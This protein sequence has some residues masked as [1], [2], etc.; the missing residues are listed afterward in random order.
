MWRLSI[1][2]VDEDGPF[3][4]FEGMARILTVIEGK[5]MVL[6]SEDG[7][8]D[9]AYCKP[10]VFSGEAKINSYL[11]NGPIRDFN[12]IYDPVQICAE[13]KLV[14]KAFNTRP[15]Q[16]LDCIYALYCIAG[17]LTVD[18]AEIDKGSLALCQSFP[19]QVQYSK[20]SVALLVSLAT[21]SGR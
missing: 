18:T 10:T 14:T 13:V 9:A 5:G 21:L 16:N 6:E 2:E 3:S 20:N 19:G 11:N 15:K 1:A 12:V 7:I 4:L 8:L 17:S